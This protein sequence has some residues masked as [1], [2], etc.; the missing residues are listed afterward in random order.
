M[1]SR[2]NLCVLLLSTLLAAC[3]GGG[4]DASGGGT[5]DPV[6]LTVTASPGSVT[7]GQASTLNWSSTGADSCSASGAWTGSKPTSGSQSTGPLDASRTYQLT[8]TGAGGSQTRSA[9]VAVESTTP[10]PTLTL[11]ASP[12]TIVAGA[13]ATLSWNSSNATTCTASGGWSGTKSLTGSASVSPT[14]TT[15]YTL[16]CTG[17]GGS[18][19]RTATV[20][21]TAAPP[22]P[23]VTLSANPTTINSGASSTLTWA[24]TNATSCTASGAWS[25]SKAT[26]G[27]QGTGALTGT[28]TYTLTCTGAG[29]SASDSVTVIVTAAPPAPTVTLSANPTT[30]SSGASSTLTWASTNATSCTASG[31]WSGS[32]ATSGSQGT[33]ALTGTATYTLTCTGA[34]GSASDSVTVTVG[35]VAGPAFPLHTETGKR[36]LVDANGQPFFI[37]GDTP[38]SLIAQ[39]KREEVVQYLDDRRAKGFNTILVN[40]IEHLFADNAPANAYGDAPFVS[41]GDFATP[42]PAY[43][44]HAE[45]VVAQAAERQMLVL[46]TPAYMGF[47]GGAPG[48]YQEMVAN[49][50]AKLRA[51]GQYVANRF[52]AYDNII[53]VQGG[54][55]NPPEKELL[56]ALAQGIRD[57]DPAALQTFHGARG[58]SALGFFGT[59]ESWLKVNDIY[60]TESTVVENAFTEYARSAMPF[61]LIEARY[62]NEGAGTETVVRS[63]AYQAVLSGAMGHLMGNRPVWGFDAGWQTAL[64]SPAATTLQVLRTLFEGLAWPD[65]VPDTS[66]SLL[67]AGTGSGIT[68]AAAAKSTTGSIGIVYMPSIRTITVNLDQLSGPNVRVRWFDPTNGSYATIAGSP[69]SASGSRDFTPTG[70]NSRGLGD[71]VLTLESVP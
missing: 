25:G 27:S 42:N 3:G 18:I 50:A 12:T 59:G 30:I 48:W 10:A 46:M 15:S 6:T 19:E 58:T 2:T 9:S 28:A 26:S 63:Q 13:N 11:T 61:F 43:F 70:N 67:L 55:F 68:R 16:A 33:G 53:W 62:E 35:S 20:T 1:S 5:P 21:V 34:G 41:P 71:W 32:K 36:Y 39:P 8:C 7:A 22:A 23:T 64:N 60:T 65:L 38:W 52:A 56:R 54:D 47:N 40:L 31:A 44:D 24:S 57:V 4:G 69:F 29:G 49:G 14:T 37:H 51:Y 17:A 66:A 45:Y